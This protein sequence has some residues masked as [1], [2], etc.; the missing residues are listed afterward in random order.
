M[1]VVSEAG[2]DYTLARTWENVTREKERSLKNSGGLS[3]QCPI[4][5]AAGKDSRKNWSKEQQL[6]KTIAWG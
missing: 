4:C 6:L 2:I 5:K 3:R 1:E